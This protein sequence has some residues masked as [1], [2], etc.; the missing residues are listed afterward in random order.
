MAE[1]TNTTTVPAENVATP[2][3]ENAGDK[4][5]SSHSIIQNAL[6]QG[7]IDEEQRTEEVAEQVKADKIQQEADVEATMQFA[8][9]AEAAQYFVEK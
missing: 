6:N 3:Q 2:P 9:A 4:G 8:S 5:F 1:A 7:V